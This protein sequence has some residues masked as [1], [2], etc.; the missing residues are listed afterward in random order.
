MSAEQLDVYDGYNALA[1]R[2]Q[3]ERAVRTLARRLGLIVLR[4]EDIGVLHASYDV[5]PLTLTELG[6]RGQEAA[7]QF[8]LTLKYRMDEKLVMAIILGEDKGLID[9]SFTLRGEDDPEFLSRPFTLH[10][11]IAIIKPRNRT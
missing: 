8:M 3:E 6:E 5:D 9:R 1:Q 10:H 2:V 11:E 4:K 7:D